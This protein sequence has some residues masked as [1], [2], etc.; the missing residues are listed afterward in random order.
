MRLWV[1]PAV[2][3]EIADLPGN[4]SANGC[5]ALSVSFPPTR[6]RH[7]AGRLIFLTMYG[8]RALRRVACGW[9]NGGLST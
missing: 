5:G 7:R 6:A 8:S 4:V 2:I 1:K 3:D 9:S